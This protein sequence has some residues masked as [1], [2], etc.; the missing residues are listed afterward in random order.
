MGIYESLGVKPIVNATGTFT[1]LGGSLMPPEV[2]QA[3]AEAARQFVCIEDLQLQAGNIIAEIVG[4]EAAYVTT[5]AYAAIVLSIAAC[6]TGLDPEKMDRL[7]HTEG[8]PHDVVMPKAQR[9]SY[10]HAAEA[11]GGRIVE[12]GRPDQCTPEELEA[13]IT[14]QTVAIFVFPEWKG[15]ISL[16]QTVEVGKRRGIPVVVDASGRLDEPRRLWDYVASGA[17]LVCF[18]GGKN[19]RGPQASGFVCGRRDLIQAMAW[20][21]LD[22]DFTPGVSTAPRELLDVNKMPYLPRQGIGRGYK[23]GKEEIV[24]LVTALRLFAKKDHAAERVGWEHKLHYIVDNLQGIPHVRAEYLPQGDFHK[25]FPYARVAIDEQA[26]GM[27]G[28]QF[29]LALKRGDPPVHPSER[30]LDRGAILINAFSL[31][32]GDEKTIVRRVREVVGATH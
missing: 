9:N 17:D 14:D 12:A 25:G 7:P 32:D 30:E 16:A 31:V 4:A 15:G 18:S 23:A 8:M 1:R 13:A 27:T 20:Q 21:H 3:M 10:D 19:I 6:M 26:L 5:G 11:A 2:V 22:M 29:I 28:A 24:G